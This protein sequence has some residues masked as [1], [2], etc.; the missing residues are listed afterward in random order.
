MQSVMLQHYQLS[1]TIHMNVKTIDMWFTVDPNFC[2]LPNTIE[3]YK[4]KYLQDAND[5]RV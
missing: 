4:F 5:E 3:D 2:L 1:Q